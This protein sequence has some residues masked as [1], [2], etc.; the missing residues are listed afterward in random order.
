MIWMTQLVVLI[1]AQAW[2][3]FDSLWGIP[4]LFPVA[5]V[6]LRKK[7]REIERKEQAEYLHDFQYLLEEV[8]V[9][10]RARYSLENSFVNACTLFLQT[11]EKAQHRMAGEA[12]ILLQSLQMNLPI[13]TVIEAM[14]ERSHLAEIEECSEILGLG[15]R[16][17]GNLIALFEQFCQNLRIKWEVEEEIRTMVAEKRMEQTIMKWMPVGILAYLR[18]TNAAYIEGL[19]HNPVGVVIAVTAIVVMILSDEWADRIMNITV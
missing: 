2:L 7:K 1:V 15:K 3:F 8:I 11:E 17:G 14:T 6:F 9:S 5:V 18:V 4:A 12:H 16:N 19:Y 10:L 13:E